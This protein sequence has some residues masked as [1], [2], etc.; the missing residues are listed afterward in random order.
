MQEV[1]PTPVTI[2]LATLFNTV[3][4]ENRNMNHCATS[5]NCSLHNSKKEF[6]IIY[7]KIYG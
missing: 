5:K 7:K 6:Y 3:H 2:Y 4:C 1:F